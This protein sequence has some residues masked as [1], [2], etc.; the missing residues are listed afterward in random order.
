MKYEFKGQGSFVSL[1]KENIGGKDYLRCGKVNQ[2]FRFRGIK[3]PPKAYAMEVHNGH[4]YMR[5]KTFEYLA[6]AF[7]KKQLSIKK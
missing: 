5:V 6:T 4:H 1:N 7:R 2:F 3:E